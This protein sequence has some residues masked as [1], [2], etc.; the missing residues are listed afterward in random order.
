VVR[1]DEEFERHILPETFE[2]ILEYHEA[3]RRLWYER[4]LKD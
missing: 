1:G 4:I 3:K 2:D